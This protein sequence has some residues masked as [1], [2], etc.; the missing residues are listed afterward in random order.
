MQL[1]AGGSRR[2][3]GCVVDL[4]LE[5]VDGARDGRTHQDRDPR[6]DQGGGGD[7]PAAAHEALFP[8]QASEPG[9]WSADY[10]CGGILG[11]FSGWLFAAPAALG[12]RHVAE[13][14]FDVHAAARVCRA[15]ALWTFDTLA[16][17]ERPAI[18]M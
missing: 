7:T 11:L 2:R 5:R 9:S 3:D 6:G 12:R 8:E 15:V 16:H 14:L 1:D 4:N 17:Q 13:H 18:G 10:R